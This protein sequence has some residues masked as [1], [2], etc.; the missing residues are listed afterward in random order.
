LI[1]GMVGCTTYGTASKIMNLLPIPGVTIA[2]KTGTAQKRVKQGDKVVTINIAWFICF[3][4]ADKP[5][6]AMAVAVE[7]DT[8]G[9]S[10]RGGP[11]RSPDREC[12]SPEI[13]RKEEP[14]RRPKARPV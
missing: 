3:A 13:F 12:R 14:P 7:G 11:R 9:E 4:P 6:I 5:E 8:G 10:L 1:D 2:G